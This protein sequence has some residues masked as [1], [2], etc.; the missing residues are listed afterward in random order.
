MTLLPRT[1]VFLR[2]AALALVVALRAL[3]QTS[4]DSTGTIQGRVYN[5]AA[6]EYIR[7]AEVRLE[8]TQRVT[9][10]E[11][12]G[13]FRF[14][15]VPAGSVTLAISYSG[16][17]A[18]R[19][20][21]NV[22]AGAPAVREINLTSTA[23]GN[24]AGGDALRLDPFM[25]SS[26]RE[27]NS[28]A[29]AAQRRNMDIMTS[30]AS[31]IFGDVMDGNV[32]EFIKYLPGVDLDYVE[33]LARGP[34]L[35]G[36]D[37]QYV[38]V[39]FDGVRIASADS[40]RGGAE[41]GRATS[42]EGFSITAVESIEITRTTSAESD[43]D[44]PA[45][46]INMRT[47]RAFERRGR[48]FSFNTAVSFNAEEFTRR[49]TLGP[50]DAMNYKWCPN[51]SLEY[52]QSFLNQ[53]LGVLASYNLSNSY[54]EQYDIQVSHNRTPTAADPRPMVV[55]QIDFKDGPKF[56]EKESL[57]L[58]ADYKATPRLVLS[59]NAIYTYAGGEFHNRTFTFVGANDNNNANNGRST[60]I[61][62]GVTSVR[63]N[64]TTANTVPALNN[65]ASSSTEI[66]YARTFSP[67]FE[68]KAGAWIFEGNA[69]YSRA[70][71]A[72]DS[73]E[74]GYLASEGGSVA[75]DWIA[76]RPHPGSW[77]WTIRQL[78]GPN[79]FDRRNFTDTNNR[80]GGTRVDSDGRNWITEIWSGQASGRW[81]LPFQRFPTVLK[82]GGKWNEEDRDNNNTTPWEIWS[83]V[84][85]GGNTVTRQ[86]TTG[87]NIISTFGN[88]A[89]VGPQFISPHPFDMGT[90]NGLTMYNIA[91]AQGMPQRVNRNAVADFFHARPDLFVHTGTPENF[92][93]AF[94]ANKRD[95]R[96]TIVAGF[97]QADVRLTPKLQL[98]FGLRAEETKNALKEFDPLLR[99]QVLAAGYTANAAGTNGGRALTL[100]GMKYQFMSQPRVTRH[101]SYM[102]T[103]PSALMKYQIRPNLEWQAGF[104]KA[105]SRPPIDSLTGLWT[106]DE[107]ALR[108]SAPN[109]ELQP[110]H[111]QNL[112]SRL[113]YY[114]GGHSPGQVSV[115]VSQ[116]KIR[117]LR[118][119]FDYT[120][121]EFGVEDPDFAPFM[122]RTTR[123]STEQR[124]FRNLELAYNQTL[125][126]LPNE[127]LRG[128]NVNFAY[129]RAYASQ[130]RNNLAP[131]RLTSRLGYSYRRFSGNV[132]MVYKDR[133]PD[134]AYGL[135]YGELTQFDASL[136]W[137]LTQRLTLYV[138]GR[139]ITGVPILRYASPTNVE[140][141]KQ[142]YLRRLNEYGA[143]WV[144]GVRGV[145]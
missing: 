31:D 135:Y 20:T 46:T 24:P 63:T 118:E 70:H 109:P 100:E 101:S 113:A 87:A 66:T 117:N 49:K 58:T 136:N 39:S 96:Q 42:F 85:P 13:S 123:N 7:D 105:I 23:R 8:G 111:S 86:A 90:T 36:M 6:R 22:A 54:T 124:R 143:N 52:S 115:Q 89:N 130:R 72:F 1:F 95:F 112:Q 30:V 14:D 129:T 37:S 61:G 73:L 145:F 69:A 43:A 102:N 62:D 71:N 131:H 32:G 59:F 92:Y 34:R 140:E 122:F 120:A 103:F 18:V 127:V 119:T 75:A 77:E 45:G 141:G 10:T 98:R 67:K 76:T 26:E 114:F 16:Y 9:F 21:F 128:I 82:F 104:N 60:M 137:R 144:F 91:G 83:Y 48:R 3:A 29:V 28:K 12:D 33:S 116:N 138:Q 106:V 38:G 40:V 99:A 47:K 5:P 125:G 44:S 107:V 97:G 108:V 64:R 78:S 25:V 68:Y 133:A 139:N 132:G 41:N 27:G 51:Y 134:G 56:H 55:R 11:N 50:N 126:F 17:N 80:S 53:R 142:K 93:T 88:W 65:G 15:G 2:L 19:E 79:W 4:A 35:G 121:S 110:E 94:V 57:L 81:A 84:G 74:R